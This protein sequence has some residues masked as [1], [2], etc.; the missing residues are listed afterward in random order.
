V[1]SFVVNYTY[2]T[3]GKLLSTTGSKATTLGVQNPFR[4]RGYYYDTETGLY[5]LQSRYYDPET[6][7]F[8]NADDF[9]LLLEAADNPLQ[10]NLYTY[11]ENNPI[12]NSDSTG[13]RLTP[14][15]G[16]G[17]FYS[18]YDSAVNAWA[19][20]YAPKSRDVEYGA[21][22]YRFRVLFRT[23]YFMGETYQGFKTQNWYTVINGLG[24][25][26]LTSRGLIVAGL[27][28]WPITNLQL[29]GFA[30][31]HP[32]GTSPMPS[33]PDIWMKRLGFFVGLWVFPIAWY[34]RRVFVRYF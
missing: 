33:G 20:Y 4:Y 22:I 7:R 34:N 29:I 10:A 5:Y 17:S 27:H 18:S 21:M 30:H 14:V 19:S 1:G 23:Y 8:L 11:C 25:G 2:D 3:W 16:F 24:A 31:T 6:G 9:T 13:Y 26:F 12:I 32:L 28:Y 15:G